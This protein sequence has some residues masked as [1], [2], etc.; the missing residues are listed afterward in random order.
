MTKSKVTIGVCVRNCEELIEGAINSVMD[1]DFPQELM[2]VILVDDGSEDKTVSVIN[3][4]AP[5]MGT[6]VSI[7]RQNWKG[8]GPAR[9]VVVN[10]AKSEY[11]VWVDGDMRLPREFVTKQVEFMERNP[12][13]GI[14][15]G[16]Y[17]IYDGASLVAYLENVEA[18]V[19]L[20]TC[21]Q[22]AVSKP[23]GTGGSIYRVRA[24]KK[25]GGFDESITGGG[26]DTDAEYRIRKVGWLLQLT[27]AEFYEIRRKNWK[28]LWDEYFWHGSGG[29]SILP[30]MKQTRSVLL[31]MF[32]PA[33]VLLETLLSC[34]AYKL[35]HRKVVFLLPFHWIFKRAAWCTGFAM[36]Y[37]NGYKSSS[38]DRAEK[39]PC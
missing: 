34:E 39:Q 3:S 20:L 10:N 12:R 22:N 9:N 32:P 4:Y 18:L 38:R 21:E 8:V 14:G 17:G 15:K 35:V 6:Q 11:I 13:V 19:E 31:K 37:V 26:E 28:A 33:A 16:R 7:F 1:Q 24:I 36:S 25:V 2:E 30:T 23:L 29:H 5:K 27:P